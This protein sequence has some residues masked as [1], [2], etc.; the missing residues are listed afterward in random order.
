MFREFTMAKKSI[1]G[2]ED[3]V[4]VEEY[5]VGESNNEE[6]DDAVKSIEPTSEELMAAKQ[7]AGEPNSF[8]NISATLF[9]SLVE[10]GLAADAGE[11]KIMRGFKWH[12][13]FR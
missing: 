6:N 3:L 9:K 10:K 7:L 5:I 12:N 1:Y 11:G 2:Y 4:E 8:E 13:H